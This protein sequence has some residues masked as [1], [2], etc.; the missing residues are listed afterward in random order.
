M[1]KIYQNPTTVNEALVQCHRM[2]C[3]LVHK[4]IRNNKQD[5]ADGYQI[6]AIGLTRAFNDF[7]TTKSNAKFTTVAY[8]YIAQHLTDFYA[9]KQYDYYN[10]ISGKEIDDSIV[11]TI[12]S[13]AE[14][15][16]GFAD[17]LK[18]MTTVEK[19]A[20]I[21]RAQGYTYAEIADMLNKIKGNEY[22]LH[23]VRRLQMAA[24]ERAAG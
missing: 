6:A 8:R 3:K 15:S 7:D 2:M 13:S 22:T 16:I 5:F 19:I 17:T 10:S 18:G 1:T 14:A 11:G 20:T 9:R 24:V 12:N 21:A 23:Q 4:Y